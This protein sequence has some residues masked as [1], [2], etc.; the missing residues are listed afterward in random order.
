MTYATVTSNGM[1]LL[2]HILMHTCALSRLRWFKIALG[3]LCE[4]IFNAYPIPNTM[5]PFGDNDL[6]A[7]MLFIWVGV[8]GVSPRV[9]QPRV[10]VCVY[11]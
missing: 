5:P 7:R 10:T 2:N 4:T 6:G 9:H 8:L 3:G 11:A 1:G